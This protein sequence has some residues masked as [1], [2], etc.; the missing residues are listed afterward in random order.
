MEANLSKITGSE[1]TLRHLLSGAPFGL[2][3]YQREY[4]WEETQVGELLD[5]LA[6]R[7]KDEFDPSHERKAVAGYRPYFL[8]PI[9]TAQRE[10]I[11]YL[12]DGQQRI[13]TL[14]L[15]LIYLRSL[16]TET[17]PSLA[18]SLD[19]LIFSTAYGEKTFNLDVDERSACLNAILEQQDFDT[20]SEPDSV[21]NLWDR[22]GTITDRFD[23]E[24]QGYVLPYFTDWLQEKV[25]LV[26]IAAPDQD[27]ALEIFETMND[28]GLRLSNT[29]MLKSYLLA[30]TGSADTIRELNDQWRSRVTEL[31]DIEANADAEFAK[32]WLRSKH[33]E[34]QRERKQN[35]SPGDFDVIGTAFHKWV[36]DNSERLDLHRDSDFQRFVQH[37]FL[38]LSGRYIELLRAS[39]SLQPELKHVFYNACTGLTLQLPVILAAVTP[40]DDDSEFRDKAQTVAAALDIFVVRRMVNFRNFGYSTVSYTMFNL[41]K[42]LRNQPVEVV[43]KVLSEWL[44]SEPDGLDGITNFG[45][46]KRNR[47]HIRYLLARMTAW[48][49]IEMGE[50]DP[51]ASYVDRSLAD[52]FEVEHIW[53]NHFERHEHEFANQHEFDDH[54][55]KFGDL[56]LLPKSFNASYGDM[57]YSDKLGHYYGQNWLARSLHPKNYENNPNFA[58]LCSNHLLGFKP[59]ADTFERADITTRQD[60]YQDIAQ[61]IWAPDYV[62]L[63]P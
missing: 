31:A 35:A 43:R 54:R 18:S 6:T 1:H 2:D 11:R 47:K 55:N 38:G 8:G 58:R 5:D 49:H 45:L 19:Q 63:E 48:I 34:T 27:M 26:D 52:P 50:P 42:Q 57:P 61:I 13:T 40:D 29:D 20:S 60:L 59:H 56:V 30:R 7:F 39:Q 28:R 12:V 25:I 33:A 51:F 21:R 3:F 37:E 15:L 62:G 17:Q 14:T 41:M 16:A 46:T 10:G 36:R 9:V 32:A 23:E 24:L 4:S 53:A 44:A 22:Y